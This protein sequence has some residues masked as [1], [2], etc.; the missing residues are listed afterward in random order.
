MKVILISWCELERPS[1]KDYEEMATRLAALGVFVTPR[2]RFL[3]R[4]FLDSRPLYGMHSILARHLKKGAI[5]L[6]WAT[7]KGEVEG[8][9]IIPG[10]ILDLNV[11]FQTEVREPEEDNLPF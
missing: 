2:G 1:F 4:R 8:S 7:E 9:R 3:G 10:E 5:E 6:I 11:S